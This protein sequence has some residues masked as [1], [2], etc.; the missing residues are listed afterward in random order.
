MRVSGAAL[1]QRTCTTLRG[2][3]MHRAG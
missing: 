3:R 2:P 1:D